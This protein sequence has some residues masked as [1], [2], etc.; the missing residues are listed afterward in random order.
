MAVKVGWGGGW[1]RMKMKVTS[2]K[3]AARQASFVD[4]KIKAL[5]CPSIFL[6][7]TRSKFHGLLQTLS[8]NS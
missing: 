3:H 4:V 6:F 1:W 5:S 2:F 8:A 7:G